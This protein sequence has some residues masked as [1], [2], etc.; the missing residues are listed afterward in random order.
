MSLKFNRTFEFV[1]AFAAL[2]HMSF[3]VLSQFP[4]IFKTRIANGAFVFVEVLMGIVPLRREKLIASFTELPTMFGHHVL[5]H[6]QFGWVTEFAKRTFQVV[7][8]HN[9]FLQQGTISEE[10]VASE[11]FV[12]CQD[13]VLTIVGFEEISITDGASKLI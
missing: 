11:T 7:L 9:V 4:K 5:I 8:S 6:S 1:I 13:V 3:L 10:G 12:I 2:N